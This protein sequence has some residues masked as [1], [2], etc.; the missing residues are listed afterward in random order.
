MRRILK[1]RRAFPSDEAAVKLMYLALQ[2]LAK[3]WTMPIRNWQQALNQFAIL[4]ED[5]VPLC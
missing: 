3:K 5:R 4:Y 1:T 2:N